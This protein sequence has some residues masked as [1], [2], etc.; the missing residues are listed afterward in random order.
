MEWFNSGGWKHTLCGIRSLV[1]TFAKPLQV[2][3]FHPGHPFLILIIVCLLG[4][5]GVGLSLLL[6]L[7]VAG[8]RVE[9][10]A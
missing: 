8:E 9:V 2:L 10:V 5:L 3:V 1:I 6:G 7:F 4:P